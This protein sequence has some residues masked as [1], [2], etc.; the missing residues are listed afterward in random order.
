MQTIQRNLAKES[1]QSN[2]Y[3][4][5]INV[6]AVLDTHMVLTLMKYNCGNTLKKTVYLFVGYEYKIK[7]FDSSSSVVKAITGRIEEVSNNYITIKYMPEKKPVEKDYDQEV[8]RG[9]T[10]CKCLFNKPGDGKYDEPITETIYTSNILDVYYNKVYDKDGCGCCP[11]DET[12]KKG[13]EVVLLG[14]SATTCRAVVVNLKMI[15]EHC[16]CDTAVRDVNLEVGNLYNIAYF[17]SKEK[18]V[19]EFEGKLITIQETDQAASEDTIVHACECYGMNNSIYNS[20]DKKYC[21]STPKDEFLSSD[22][23]TDDIL[24]TF[25]ISSDFLGEYKTVRLSWLRDCK[26][27]K[28]NPKPSGDDDNTCDCDC[29]CGKPISMVSGKCDLLIDPNTKEVKF[30]KD[31]ITDKIPL[32]EIMDFYFNCQC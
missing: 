5:M 31:S 11:S 8:T 27:L 1:Q 3:I 2:S 26:L 10:N 32:Q 22:K 25:D 29:C 9:L 12:P 14:I 21:A 20:K 16:T 7:Y 23:I 19:Y 18:A 24:L 17:N 30:T 15:E 4:G 6:E 13:V 28:K